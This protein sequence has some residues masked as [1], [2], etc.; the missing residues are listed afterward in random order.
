MKA[1][2]LSAG[3]GT[4]MQPLTNDLP[5]PL[6]QV[7]GK[8]LIEHHLLKL[9]SAGITDIIINTHYL[10]EKIID[11]LGDGRD[12][13]VNITY[14]VEDKLLNTGG[15]LLNVL[16]MIGETPFLVIASDI[17][18]SFEFRSLPD[19]LKG[20]A[21]LVLVDNPPY[22]IKGDYSLNKV[23]LIGLDSDKKFNFAGIALVHPHLFLHCK[24]SVFPISALFSKAIKQ[25]ACT[26]QYFQ[27]AWYNVGT[28][29]QLNEVNRLN[30][31][32]P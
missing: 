4:R 19:S 21:H 23:G 5:K 1:V 31:L 13:H 2:I 7:A 30:H 16:P 8:C 15:G 10:S 11:K 6:L 18:T 9:A 17:Y 26:G 20:L 29:D 27:G 25:Q 28:P 22:H 12:Y 32:S 3:L 24:E 14:S